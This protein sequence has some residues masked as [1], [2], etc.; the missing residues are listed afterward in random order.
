MKLLSFLT[1]LICLLVPI[2]S[3][4]DSEPLPTWEP[5]VI[6][7]A[8][9]PYPKARV[10]SIDVEAGTFLFDWLTDAEERVDSGN[11]VGRFT[12]ADPIAYPDDA[13]LAAAITAAAL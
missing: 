3:A 11:S 4:A 12:P 7:I 13:T 8:D 1:F 9:A 2:V 6:A 5:K 10:T